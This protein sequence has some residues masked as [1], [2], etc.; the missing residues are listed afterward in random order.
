MGGTSGA[1]AVRADDGK[2]LMVES[3]GAPNGRP[4]FLLHGTP[5]SRRGPHP[6]ASVLYRLGVKLI[7]YDRPGYGES[8]RR[9]GRLVRDAAADVRAIADALGLDSFAV[10]GRSG[11]APHALACATLLPDRVTRAAALVS[12]A[13]P[14][15]EDL[16]WFAGM[17]LANVATYRLADDGARVFHERLAPR[18]DRIRRDPLA[19]LP[20]RDPV[21]PEADRRVVA[22]IGIRSQYIEALTEAFRESGDGWADDLLAFCSPWG[23]DPAQADVPVLLW[24]G[25]DDVYSP[26]DHARWLAARMREATLVVESGKAHFGALTVL[27]QVLSWLIADDR[28]GWLSAA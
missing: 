25:A 11:G 5:G 15:A 18:K 4:V 19:G 6:R 16:D 28:R 20:L 10:V 13:P 17:S 12:I 7:G 8:E 23:F 9:P 2:Q 26:V 22:D 24:H 14:D 3:W 1:L 21:L 27:P